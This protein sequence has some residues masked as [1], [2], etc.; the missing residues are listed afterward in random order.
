MTTKLPLTDAPSNQ[1]HSAEDRLD[2]NE[3]QDELDAWFLA[4]SPKDALFTN[5]T[6]SPLDN[7]RLWVAELEG[8]KAWLEQ[9]SLNWQKE[10]EARGKYI[11][12]LKNWIATLGNSNEWLKQQIEN[13]QKEADNREKQVNEIQNWNTKLEHTKVWQQQQ[14]EKWKAEAEARNVSLIE[15]SNW[16]A[17]LE[18]GKAWLEEQVR[19]WQ[20]E[21]LLRQEQI[22]E[23]EMQIVPN[24]QKLLLQN[25]IFKLAKHISAFVRK[26]NQSNRASLGK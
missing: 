12:E 7:L 9:Q 17:E 18:T 23:F 10:A 4:Q 2:P 20:Q 22:R 5:Q 6:A 3:I 15:L 21:A 16:V 1:S 26:T 11:D 8:G 25:K 19:C 13:W 24:G 14:I